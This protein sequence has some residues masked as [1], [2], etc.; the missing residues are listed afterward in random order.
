MGNLLS[1]LRLEFPIK[2]II[3]QNPFW[4]TN[5]VGNSIRIF[6]GNQIDSVHLILFP[7]TDSR[8][9][10]SRRRGNLSPISHFPVRQ[11]S[12]SP[13]NVCCYDCR[14]IIIKTINTSLGGF[15]EAKWEVTWYGLQQ[16]L[17]ALHCSPMH[18]EPHQRR[19]GNHFPTLTD[20]HPQYPMILFNFHSTPGK[21]LRSPGSDLDGHGV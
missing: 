18:L 14:P 21:C 9:Y 12:P 13:Q 1:L 20:S 19:N 6:S 10:Y 15:I 5:C 8:H 17:D 4:L 11:K 2:I 7:L 3:S 16:A